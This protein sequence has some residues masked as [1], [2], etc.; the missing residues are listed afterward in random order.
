MLFAPDQ[1]LNWIVNDNKAHLM[2]IAMEL[3]TKNAMHNLKIDSKAIHN[4]GTMPNIV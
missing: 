4:K 3:G 1:Q 2:N